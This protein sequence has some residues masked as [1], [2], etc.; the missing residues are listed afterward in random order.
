MRRLLAVLALAGAG[1][2]AYRLAVEPWWRAW[3][4]DPD[5]TAKP[6]PGDEIVASPTA[7]ETRGIT[8]HASPASVWPWLVQMGFNRAGWYSYDQVDMAGRST[9]RILPEHQS[10]A[11]GDTVPTHPGGGFVVRAL[12]PERHLVLFLDADAAREQ[13]E[14]ARA[15]NA[16]MPSNLRMTGAFME[17]AQPTDFTASWAF[18]LEPLADGRT[19]LVERFRIRFGD[20]PDRPWTR[21]TLPI[22]GFG[23]FV[24]LR[25]QLLGIRDRAERME[26]R[27]LVAA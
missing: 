16:E 18:V 9:D 22:M 17:N 6:L 25:K 5:E 24:M 14:E 1:L 13:A 4:V 20:A 8:I 23:V 12:E 3:G 7:I 21:A 26:A 15:I 27:H 2:A 19:R 10:L 11:V